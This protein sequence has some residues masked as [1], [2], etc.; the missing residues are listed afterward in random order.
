MGYDEG[1][2][3]RLST[4]FVCITALAICA[5]ICAQIPSG[6]NFNDSDQKTLFGTTEPRPPTALEFSGRLALS[7]PLVLLV[8]A[9]VFE[10]VMDGASRRRKRKAF[11]ETQQRN[12]GND[13]AFESDLD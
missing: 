13:P 2:R 10:L 6:F 1:M 5:A 3:F 8:T 7:S 9:F 11:R 12:N 4:L